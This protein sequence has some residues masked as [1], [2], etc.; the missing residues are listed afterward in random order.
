MSGILYVVATPIGNLADITLRAINTLRDVDLIAAEDTRT[1]HNLL[2]HYEIDTPTTSYHQ[3]NI[4]QKTEKLLEEIQSGKNIAIVS[5]AGTPGISDPGHEIIVSCIEN[6]IQVIGI[7][8]PSAAIDALVVSGLPTRRFAFEGFPPRSPKERRSSFK[9]LASETRTIVFYESPHRLLQT[10]KDM[11]LCFGERQIAVVREAT[12]MF[13]E[14]VRG[15]IES[16]IEHFTSVAPRG[17]F[18]LVIEG[19]PSHDVESAVEEESIE[20]M[21]R[22]LIEAGMTERDAVKEVSTSKSISR[23][24]VYQLMLK[25]KDEANESS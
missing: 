10:L 18:T 14:V 9:A 8:G 13:E 25:I 17:E 6:G 5:D 22:S 7:P 21:L 12:K 23:R 11:Q 4:K 3:H 16:A 15:T 20:D 1:T 2:S 19:A 24:D